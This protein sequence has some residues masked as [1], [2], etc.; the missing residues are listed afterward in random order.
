MLK[1]KHRLSARSDFFER[2]IPVAIYDGGPCD[3]TFPDGKTCLFS[4]LSSGWVEN[5][6]YP[7]GVAKIAC[8][9]DLHYAVVDNKASASRIRTSPSGEKIYFKEGKLEVV[10]HSETPLDDRPELIICN[11][12]EYKVLRNKGHFGSSVVEL[13]EKDYCV[14]LIKTKLFRTKSTF[15]ENLPLL[16]RVFITLLAFDWGV[17]NNETLEKNNI[18]DSPNS[19]T[20]LRTIIAGFFSAL[21]AIIVIIWNILLL[22]SLATIGFFALWFLL[23]YIAYLIF[24]YFIFS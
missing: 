2:G 12:K 7:K 24:H 15:K 16:D 10:A 18:N 3:L 4:L 22:P 19:F 5:P 1:V 17:N 20:F 9:A 13:Y 21:I 23:C 14:A 8:I 6:V 11:K